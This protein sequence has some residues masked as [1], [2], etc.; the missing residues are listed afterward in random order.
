NGS[1]RD[2]ISMLD[3]CRSYTKDK[4]TRDNIVDILGIVD[5]DVF[6]ELLNYVNENKVEMA[7]DIVARAIDNGKDIDKF[8]SDF[9]WYI[10]NVL[11]SQN[12]T[13]P[14]ESLN[15]TKVSFDKIKKESVKIAKETLIYYIEEL[16]KALSVMRYDENRRVI[17]ET[18]LI[19]LANP[20]TNYTES[21]V[22]A[23]IKELENIKSSHTYVKVDDD[24]DK[25]SR[26]SIDE[27]ANDEITELSLNKLTYD[28]INLVIESWDTIKSPLNLVVKQALARADL[29]PG[30]EKEPG[31]VQ[32]L[33][34]TTY[35]D[36]LRGQ[37]EIIEKNLS[38]KTREVLER[39]VTY[40]IIDKSKTKYAEKITFRLED[41]NDKI[42]GITIGVEDD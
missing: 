4:L 23:R 6:A 18:T 13:K 15:I 28:E 35:Y 11:I 2:A 7:C 3:R 21:S 32:V 41:Y 20:E 17:L 5:D 25:T 19:R 9:I 33:L 37:I 40:K 22:L 24:Q 12:I 14:I 10:R 31:V 34:P 26:K 30:S 39:E 29:I 42:Q 8:T 1:M 36:I 16:S 27:K 38:T